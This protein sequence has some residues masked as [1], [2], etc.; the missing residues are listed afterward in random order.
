M[1]TFSGRVSNS[2]MDN[3][4]DRRLERVE[5]DLGELRIKI[6]SVKA[7]FKE[8]IRKLKSQIEDLRGIVTKPKLN[9]EPPR[10]FFN[11]KKRITFASPTTPELKREQK[12]PKW[13]EEVN[14]NV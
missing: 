3:K 4:M 10:N 2:H 8:E 12:K 13:M 1:F 9:P 14:I 7:V 5:F 6:N 11:S